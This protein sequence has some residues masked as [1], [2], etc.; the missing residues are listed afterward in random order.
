MTNLVLYNWRTC[1]FIFRGS[2]GHS[3]CWILVSTPFCVNTRSL[4]ISPVINSRFK[5]QLTRSQLRY[6]T[7]K[8]HFIDSV[9][10]RWQW[11]TWCNRCTQSFTTQYPL[12]TAIN[13]TIR[14]LQTYYQKIHCIRHIQNKNRT[15]R[16]VCEMNNS[17]GKTVWNEHFIGTLFA[18]VDRGLY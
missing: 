1:F 7:N 4:S 17:V 8:I 12:N 10:P 2:L 13:L 14:N 16:L 15:I 5:R 18:I 6:L 3:V 11:M 9:M